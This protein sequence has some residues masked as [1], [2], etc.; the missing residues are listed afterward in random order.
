MA[1][2]PDAKL[3]RSE[4]D[5]NGWDTP[6]QLGSSALVPV[7]DPNLDVTPR[8]PETEPDV[9]AVGGL[10]REVQEQ[11]FAALRSALDASLLPL[12]A[13]QAQ[14]EARLEALKAAPKPPPPPPSSVPHAAPSAPKPPPSAPAKSVPPPAMKSVPPPRAQQPSFSTEVT[15]PSQ[16]PSMV[17]TS[18]GLVSMAPAPKRDLDLSNVG[19]IEVPDFGSNRAGRVLVLLLLGGVVAAIIATILSRV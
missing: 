7:A 2:Q 19:P 3:R 16:K 10:P 11:L 15:F 13:K 14:L 17:T 6:E 12:L 4:P 8:V 5:E 1:S 18:Y 9:P